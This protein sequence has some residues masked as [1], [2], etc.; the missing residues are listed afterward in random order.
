MKET[1]ENMI[2]A[3]N[4]KSL[5]TFFSSSN[6]LLHLSFFLSPDELLRLS[7]ACS[8]LSKCLDAA[9]AKKINK[10]FPEYLHKNELKNYE[11]QNLKTLLRVLSLY[12]RF[13]QDFAINAVN[14]LRDEKL[15]HN[16]LDAFLARN[17]YPD[18]CYFP[19]AA[20]IKGNLMRF[21]YED[22]KALPY[23]TD[24]HPP[25]KL[26]KLSLSLIDEYTL[27]DSE[28]K[29]A[30]LLL[31]DITP[32]DA[33]H[34]KR[35]DFLGLNWY[36]YCPLIEKLFDIKQRL[37][38]YE[39]SY[40]F[41]YIFRLWESYQKWFPGIHKN[42]KAFFQYWFDKML[43]NKDEFIRMQIATN[44]FLLLDT[45]SEQMHLTDEEHDYYIDQCLSNKGIPCV[46]RIGMHYHGIHK[47]KQFL[48]SVVENKISHSPGWL[49]K[50]YCTFARSF[51]R[52]S[53]VAHDWG[54]MSLITDWSF[55][56]LAI[57]Q[58]YLPAFSRAIF[59]L[60]ELY[61]QSKK[62]LREIL[63][64]SAKLPVFKIIFLA[65]LI[66]FNIIPIERRRQSVAELVECVKDFCYDSV[67]PFVNTL[68]HFALSKEESA[69]NSALSNDPETCDQYTKYC[70]SF[71]PET[72]PQQPEQSDLRNTDESFLIQTL[73]RT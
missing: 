32:E 5:N 36:F 20:Y 69:R 46:E 17:R 64:N 25:L 6:H 66:L 12:T 51:Y 68:M 48:L 34:Y 9:L 3:G 42:E 13:T 65:R 15:I 41:K 54:Y 30:L 45:Y 24:P 50:F 11:G 38:F 14:T 16:T 8:Y 31:K 33:A 52:G 28:K 58:S 19:W 23:F 70:N 47:I 63:N 40:H 18:I 21:R 37:Q 10:H 35:N 55:T 49:G 22:E 73:L 4:T 53:L 44:L 60:N 57:Y 7:L 59:L 26:A 27:N 71:F 61:R 62:S 39:E 2:N 56:W 43:E 29:P 1:V 67:I 72:K